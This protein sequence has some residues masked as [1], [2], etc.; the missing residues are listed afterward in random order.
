MD[1]SLSG[2]NLNAYFELKKLPHRAPVFLAFSV[3][4]LCF[5]TFVLFTHQYLNRTLSLTHNA[6]K[7]LKSP[8]QT[9]TLIY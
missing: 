9:T 5:C 3:S 2:Q 4:L 7:T 1:V 6:D 8:N